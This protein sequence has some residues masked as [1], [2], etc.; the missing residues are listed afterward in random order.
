[1]SD[2]ISAKHRRG[3]SEENLGGRRSEFDSSDEQRAKKGW[4]EK[5]D[6]P[7]KLDRD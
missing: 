5:N 1:M 7:V 2:H 6:K 4:K 3:K